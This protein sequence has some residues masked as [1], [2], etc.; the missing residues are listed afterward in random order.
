MMTGQD[1]RIL[2]AISIQDAKKF[3]DECAEKHEPVSI[4]AL[5]RDAH[6]IVLDGWTVTSGHTK[7]RTHNYRNPLNGEMR[8]VI[9][10]LL[11]YINNHPIYI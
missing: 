10:V 1:K 9:D 4:V 5:A 8:K 11:F 2:G 7:G 6:K 3:L